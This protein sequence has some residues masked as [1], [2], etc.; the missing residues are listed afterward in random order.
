MLTM[1]FSLVPSSRDESVGCDL[2]LSSTSPE[3]CVRVGELGSIPTMAINAE[4]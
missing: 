4:V 1:P 3:T 2:E